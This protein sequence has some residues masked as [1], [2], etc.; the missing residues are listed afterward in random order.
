[1]D[2]V[3]LRVTLEFADPPIHQIIVTEE[4]LDQLDRAAEAEEPVDELHCLVEE[5]VGHF[6]PLKPSP[7]SLQE[8]PMCLA[9]LPIYVLRM[10]SSSHKCS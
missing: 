5:N 2:E 4:L 9:N 6:V 3:T 8:H 10:A 7:T 1:M